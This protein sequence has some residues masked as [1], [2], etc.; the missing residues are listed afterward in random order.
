MRFS[1][2]T[3]GV[4]ELFRSEQGASLVRLLGSRFAAAMLR[5]SNEPMH[6]PGGGGDNPILETSPKPKVGRLPNISHSKRAICMAIMCSRV[7]N[8]T[9]REWRDS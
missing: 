4:G 3:G 7:M 6:A 1:P 2:M 8:W 5:Q 9:G